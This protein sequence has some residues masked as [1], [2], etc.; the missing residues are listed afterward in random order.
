M[1]RM[2][3]MLRLLQDERGSDL[4]LAAGQP[5]RMRRKGSLAPIEGE[6]ALTDAA[7]RSLLREITNDD[8]W[9]S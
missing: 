9:T 1:G 5:P 2:E 3:A 6:A 8:Q 7:L 4:H